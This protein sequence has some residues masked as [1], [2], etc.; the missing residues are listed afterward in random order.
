MAVSPDR[1]LAAFADGYGR[2]AVLDVTKGHLIRL[3]KG[4][5]DAQCAFVQVGTII[6]ADS[7]QN[8]KF[9]RVILV[10]LLCICWWL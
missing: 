2:V 7:Y 9:N 5:R 10:H 4:C 1:R 3:I 8:K 6:L